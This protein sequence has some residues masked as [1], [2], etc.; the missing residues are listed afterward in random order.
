MQHLL[1]W[2]LCHKIMRLAGFPSK[3]YISPSTRLW[4]FKFDGSLG[5]TGRWSNLWEDIDMS[6]VL[7]ESIDPVVAEGNITDIPVLEGNFGRMRS[8][9][10]SRSPLENVSLIIHGS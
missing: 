4:L 9:P 2:E 3:S 7:G 5:W 8:T 6:S 1:E 10:E